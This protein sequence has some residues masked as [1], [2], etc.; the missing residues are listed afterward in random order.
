MR[1]KIT[2]LLTLGVVGI[3][4]AAEPP[5]SYQDAEAI[6]IRS[7]DT[8]EYQTYAAEFAQFNNAVRLDERGNCYSLTGGSVNLM[9]VISGARDDGFAVV[10]R[11][12][13]D[14][15]NAK[16]RC[17]ERSYNGIS[18]KAPPFLPFVLQLRMN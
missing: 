1:C 15:N 7:R 11:A 4:T 6:W 17:F 12:F 9:L 8:I 5:Q 18:T 2:V 14:T 13:Y 3:A 10:E 16:A